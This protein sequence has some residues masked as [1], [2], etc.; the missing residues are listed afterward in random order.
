MSAAIPA[1]FCARRRVIRSWL[2]GSY[3]MLP[4]AVGLL[5]PADAVL[6]PRR[7]RHRPRA[8]ERLLVAEVREELAVVAVRLRRERRRDVGQ[9]VDVRQQPRLRAVR[10]IRVR[11]QID[12]RPVL[13]RDAARLDRRVE[14]VR[15][16]QRCDDRHR[17]L[18]V[19]AEQ[20]HQQVALLRL[21]RHSRRRAGALDV[22]DHE[23]QLEHDREPDRLGLQH[24]ARDRRRS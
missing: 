23:R 16:R 21:R 13:Q 20:H 6:E 14:A 11:E 5:E 10:E 7:A 1:T 17:R 19:A 2:S 24:D 8:R 3:E 22:A 12:G 15:R 18:A 9:R 4:R